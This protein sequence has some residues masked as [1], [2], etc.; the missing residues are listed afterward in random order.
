MIA[1]LV[2]ILGFLIGFW[3]GW[4]LRATGTK[5]YLR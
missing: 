2:F 5:I 1:F 4:N 3:L